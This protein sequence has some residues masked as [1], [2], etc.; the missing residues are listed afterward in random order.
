MSDCGVNCHGRGPSDQSRSR[1]LDGVKKQVLR[2]CRKWS[3]T[4]FT[5]NVYKQKA[6][7]VSVV[8]MGQKEW[9]VIYCIKDSVSVTCLQLLYLSHTRR[10]R[11]SR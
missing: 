5:E 11:Q 4:S 7:G 2:E 10:L 8:D 3:K 6:R 9:R 1:V